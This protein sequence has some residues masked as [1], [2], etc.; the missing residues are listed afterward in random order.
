MKHRTLGTRKVVQNDIRF[1]LEAE[2]EQW[3]RTN[4]SFQSLPLRANESIEQPCM[5]RY[6]DSRGSRQ[7]LEKEPQSASPGRSRRC[8]VTGSCSISPTSDGE[9]WSCVVGRKVKYILALRVMALACC[10]FFFS[11][12]PPGPPPPLRSTIILMFWKKHIEI[13]GPTG[14]WAAVSTCREPWNSRSRSRTK[15]LLFYFAVL[16]F[17]LF[18]FFWHILSL[19]LAGVFL[20]FIFFLNL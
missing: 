4:R 19:S 13:N 7:Q 18:L 10:F 8:R 1:H 2:G 11:W 17:F 6:L 14:L 3:G 15:H 9:V 16:C 20:F 12:T 5:K